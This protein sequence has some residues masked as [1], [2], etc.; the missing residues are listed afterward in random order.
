[1][2]LST[3]EAQEAAAE[4]ALTQ[5]EQLN[6]AA[7]KRYLA[8]DFAHDGSEASHAK[9]EAAD[10]AQERTG[11]DLDRAR[12][13]RDTARDS[14]IAFQQEQGREE[15]ARLEA[16]TLYTSFVDAQSKHIDAA[17]K[18][19]ADLG[20]AHA[21]ITEA[22]ANHARQCG[23]LRELGGAPESITLERVARLVSELVTRDR[24]AARQPVPSQDVSRRLTFGDLCESLVETHH[25]SFFGNG[26]GRQAET[27]A[28]D[29]TLRNTNPRGPR[30]A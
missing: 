5:A 20:K 17:R 3:L 11:R 26:P 2:D 25:E 23:R 28:S 14:R 24:R 13:A 7:T 18:A 30:A 10:T 1:M 16:L 6:D 22:L 27:E 8:L 15:R 12:R 4:A 29:Y 19:A 9:V 21:A